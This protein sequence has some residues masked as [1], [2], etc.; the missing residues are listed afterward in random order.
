MPSKRGDSEEAKPYSER[1][2]WKDVTPVPQDDGPKP[3][4]VISYPPGFQEVHSYFR[5]IQQKGEY[6]ERALELTSSVID[7][8]SA[9]YTVW[10]YRRRC[11]KELGSDLLAEHNFT[12]KW[13]RDCPKNYQVWYHRRW[14]ISEMADQFEKEAA[15][16]EEA[17]KKTQALAEK[18]LEY[19]Q[20]VMQVNDDYKNYNGWSHRQFILQRF[21][22]WSQELPF[23]EDLLRDDI[24][25]NSAWNHRFTVV[26]QQQWPVSE[27]IRKRELDYAMKSI[28]SC[29]NNEC[30]WNYLGAFLGEG[31]GKVP[32]DSVP[33]VE[34]LCNEVLQLAEEPEQK[35]RF[36]LEVLAKVFEAKGLVKDALEQYAT[37]QLV[38]KIRAKYWI[39]RAAYL[40]AKTTE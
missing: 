8:N 32:W 5:A 31:E 19:H 23:V 6:S 28:R 7:H 3:L 37:L 33:A 35:C 26:R 2:D 29:A 38:D 36:A 1:E 21:N 25:N 30:P 16:P 18:E 27:E 4:A 17:K 13:A 39:W 24:R 34:K 9:N 11:L 10:Y 20:D 40:Q 15:S 14:L 12:D 22:A